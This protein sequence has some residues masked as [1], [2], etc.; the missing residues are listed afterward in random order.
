METAEIK[1][2]CKVKEIKPPMSFMGIDSKTFSVISVVFILGLYFNK[3]PKGMI[4]AVGVMLFLA[5]ALNEIGDRLP[6]V[7]KYL[8]GGPIVI[9]FACSVLVYFNLIPED[10]IKNITIFFK[11]QFVNFFIASLITGSILGT[12]RKMF[13]KASL[14]FFPAII[15][16]IVVA[17]GLVSIV[18]LITGY[19]VREAIFYIGIPIMGGGLGAGAI[20]LAEIF[21]VNMSVDPT[22]ILSRMIPAVALG[23]VIAIVVGGILDSIG[24]IK[25][26][27]TGNGK[28][29]RLES[30]SD[31]ADATQN[32]K[33][34]NEGNP[35][36]ESYGIGIIFASFFMVIGTVLN[37]FMP[38]LHTYAFM[39]IIVAIIKV[40]G[41]LPEKY[42]N[43]CSN[44]YKFSVKNL[45]AIGLVG[46]GIVFTNLSELISV[47]TPIY[48][49]IAV[50][51]IVGSV[52]G[53]GL[54]GHFFG[55]YF[56]ES[57]ISAGLCMANMG[58]A[59]DIAVLSACKRMGLIPFAQISSR[60]GGAFILILASAMLK[61]F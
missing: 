26:G 27:L 40:T 25:P 56:I 58:G 46:V 12:D 14:S 10:V 17:L 31:F 8:G 49:L 5:A 29:T 52:I 11:G 6:G 22:T 48:F 60:I 7:S 28:L 9:I 44:W 21:G 37:K 39:I 32:I 34:A 23:N 50:V 20:P 59:G 19:D 47:F 41:I 35:K 15:G 54:V 33:P 45:S 51:A 36:I 42:Q 2:N 57:S 43:D 24:K 61:L 13:I 30:A 1:S 38:G 3:I 18:A 55:L 4:G 53:A 16:G